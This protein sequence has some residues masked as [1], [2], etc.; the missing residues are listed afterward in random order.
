M[1]LAGVFLMIP[2][3]VPAS[4]GTPGVFSLS[5]QNLSAAR[6]RL[7]SGDLLL[8]PAL[9]RLRADADRA[10]RFKP[11]SVMDKQRIP[12][13]GDKHDYLSQAPYW[14]PDPEKPAGRPYI[15]HDGRHNPEAAQ[16]TDAPA[17]VRLSGHIETLGLAFYFTGQRDYAEHAVRLVRTWFL[18]QTTRM[19][20]HLR[21][22][23]FVPGRNEGRGA[24]I[25]EMRHLTQV[26]D[27]ISLIAESSAWSAADAQAF[28]AWLAEY[29]AWLTESPNGREEAAAK[30]NHGSWYDVQAVHLALVLGKVDLARNFLTGGLQKRIAVQIEPDGSQPLELARTRSLGYSLFNLQALMRL[31]RLGEQVGVDWWAFTSQDG[32]SLRAA[33]QY[34]APFVDPAKPWPRDDIA[35]AD[36][37]DLLPLLSEARRHGGDP[38][39]GILLN[40]FGRTKEQQSARWRLLL[41]E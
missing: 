34:L 13:S 12:P 35:A 31:A 3:R 6:A 41:A 37:D 25:L 8:T 18:N 15:H 22:A 29:F 5:A 26:C 14:W 19:N 4:A 16:G 39:W 2:P 32:R 23:Q 38:Q 24:G 17:W 33:L 1:R 10:L 36:R 21:Y 40:N 28:R 7:P 30:N 9:N 27:A 11:V 20:P